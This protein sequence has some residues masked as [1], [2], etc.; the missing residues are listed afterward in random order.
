MYIYKYS[1]SL[2]LSNEIFYIKKTI[3]YLK[4]HKSS[5]QI[6][7]ILKG[8]LDLYQ[9][10]ANKE[11]QYLYSNKDNIVDVAVVVDWCQRN[12][13]LTLLY[14]LCISFSLSFY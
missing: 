1:I 4:L 7:R 13:G 12:K 6:L 5:P 8:I 14:Y 10:E 2:Y 3:E 11:K 9:E